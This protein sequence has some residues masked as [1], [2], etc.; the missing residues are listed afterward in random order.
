MFLIL[1]QN[2]GVGGLIP[3]ES[4]YEVNCIG[5]NTR[6]LARYDL[7]GALAVGKECIANSYLIGPGHYLDP[8]VF[9][10]DGVGTNTLLQ[11][12]NVYA[13]TSSA[14]SVKLLRRPIWCY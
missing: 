11:F 6:G 3:W 9:F 8:P 10:A 14:A 13:M 5:L 7:S 2:D 4:V 12:L 1:N